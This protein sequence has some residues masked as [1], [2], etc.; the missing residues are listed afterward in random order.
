[1]AGETNGTAEAVTTASFLS[2]ARDLLKPKRA[3]SQKALRETSEEPSAA[4]L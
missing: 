3:G 1:M 4:F 2:F